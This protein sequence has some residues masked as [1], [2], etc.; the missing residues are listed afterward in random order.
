MWY[1]ECQ[2]N[3][4]TVAILASWSSI[5]DFLSPPGLLPGNNT[6]ITWAKPLGLANERLDGITSVRF[7]LTGDDLAQK[8]M[9]QKHLSTQSAI[10]LA[11]SSHW[12]KGIQN[13]SFNCHRDFEESNLYFVVI[14][15]AA[16]GLAPLGARPSADTEMAKF[17]CCI[18]A[19]HALEQL[20]EPRIFY[21]SGHWPETVTNAHVSAH[22][23]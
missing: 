22:F 13:L 12:W 16:D 20:H 8:K 6:Y 21:P 15:V 1:S 14:T 3:K 9:T 5:T 18:Y 7:C 4:L 23:R 10:L 17:G 2:W 11:I 19:G